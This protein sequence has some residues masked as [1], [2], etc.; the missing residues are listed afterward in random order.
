ML[1]WCVSVGGCRG[2]LW[3]HPASRQQ[4]LEPGPC[5]PSTICQPSSSPSLKPK[6]PCTPSH[7]GP[8]EGAQAAAEAPC[9]VM[10]AL[11]LRTCADASPAAAAAAACWCRGC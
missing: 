11:S 2:Q 4:L 8:A 5:Q 1:A 6:L 9:A 7:T 3:Q 10:L